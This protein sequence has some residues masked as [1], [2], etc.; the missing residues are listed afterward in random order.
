MDNQW[1]TV[2]DDGTDFDNDAALQRACESMG[3]AG[4]NLF[5]LIIIVWTA[6]SIIYFFV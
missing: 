6:G 2:C 1:A 4:E 5:V 3:Y